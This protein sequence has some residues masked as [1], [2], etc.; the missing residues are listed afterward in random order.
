MGKQNVKVDDSF[1][2][3]IAEW[4]ATIEK[5]YGTPVRIVIHKAKLKGRL[6]LRVEACEVAD[7]RVV[8]VRVK[9]PAAHPSGHATTLWGLMLNLMVK[10]HR[11]LEEYE[12]FATGVPNVLGPG[13]PQLPEVESHTSGK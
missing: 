11:E 10:L 1:A 3:D 12:N 5:D 13:Q 6:E 9:L 2:Y 7:T 4:M 8:G